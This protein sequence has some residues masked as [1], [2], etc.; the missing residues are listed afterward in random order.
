MLARFRIKRRLVPALDPRFN[1]GD[2]GDGRKQRHL[3]WFM[4]QSKASGDKWKY[5][6]DPVVAEIL[7]TIARLRLN[8]P[9]IL[10]ENLTTLPG[11]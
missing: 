2:G 8:P 10:K 5:T 1:H 3:T 9:V 7:L 11:R 6:R 4:Q